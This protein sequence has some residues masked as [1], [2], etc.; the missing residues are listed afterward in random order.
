MNEH[1]QSEHLVENEGQISIEAIRFSGT[2]KGSF[3]ERSIQDMIAAEIAK[4]LQIPLAETTAIACLVLSISAVVVGIV[5]L[6][7]P[8]AIACIYSVYVI[9]AVRA[10]VEEK[11]PLQDY[12][13]LGE[14]EPQATIPPPGIETISN[15]SPDLDEQ[16][17]PETTE[18]T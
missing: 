15:G 4:R 6:A 13:V 9:Y 7:V 12:A 11:R 10:R 3:S 1:E 2:V 8:F 5:I 18:D 14:S 16:N 17:Q